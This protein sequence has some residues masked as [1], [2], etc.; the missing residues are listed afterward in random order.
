MFL[1]LTRNLTRSKKTSN[2][3]HWELATAQMKKIPVYVFKEKGVNAPLMIQLTE[4]YG[5]FDPVSRES[6]VEAI[7]KMISIGKQLKTQEEKNRAMLLDAFGRL[8]KTI[9]SVLQS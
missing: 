1:I 8:A 9:F 5:T 2:I 3:V 7:G 4:T 6:L